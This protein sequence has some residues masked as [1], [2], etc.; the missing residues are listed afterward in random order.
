MSSILDLFRSR[1]QTARSR[2]PRDRAG[3]TATVRK[4]V[5]ALE[6]M[7]PARARYVAAFA[8]LLGRVAHADLDI[9]AEEN[10]RLGLPCG[11]RITLLLQ[12]LGPRDEH[13]IT[14][15]LAD[16]GICLDSCSKLLVEPKNK[17][18]STCFIKTSHFNS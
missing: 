14:T 8:Y 2:T 1:G 13:W 7:E 12:R 17:G 10:E 15:A 11:G 4:I 3:A 18:R 5:R 9:S 6:E 16:A